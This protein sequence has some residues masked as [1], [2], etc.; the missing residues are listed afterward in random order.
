MVSR[1]KVITPAD[2]EAPGAGIPSSLLPLADDA[3]P[4]FVRADPGGHPAIYMLRFNRPFFTTPQLFYIRRHSFIFFCWRRVSWCRVTPCAF[5]L[6]RRW[7]C[8]WPSP[9]PNVAITTAIILAALI[10]VMV[11]GRLDVTI[12]SAI[13]GIV[14]AL[15]LGKAERLNAFFWSGLAAAAA[16]AG[17]VLVFRLADP[18]ADSFGMATLL[19]ASL[20]NG[21]LSAAVT[22][23]GFFALGNIYDSTTSLQLI[24]LARPNHPL[25]QF[26]LRQAPGTY[27][28]SLQIANLAEQAAERIGANAMRVRVGA[29]FH[30]VGKSLHPEYFVENQIDDI[31]LHV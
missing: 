17:I 22:L 27:Q 12:Y 9:R 19:V 18:N 1:G 31:N 21:G 13:G 5:P 10:G 2:L 11:D 15:T 4:D 29:L 6:Q 23:L 24:E 26:M 7:L 20:I 28:H 14:A 8:W 25:L 3:Q 16:N 30:D